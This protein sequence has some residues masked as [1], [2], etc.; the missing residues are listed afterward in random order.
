MFTTREAAEKL[1]VTIRRVNALIAS[2][3]LQAEKF[4]SAWM[5][6]ER[7]VL[8]RL[9]QPVSNGR[10]KMG[11]KNPRTLASY[12]LMNRNHAVLDF[13]YNR[14]TH[15]TADVTPCEDVDWK[16]F[17]TGLIEA[18]PNRYDLATWISSR[19][20]PALRPRLPQ[21][22][23][24]SDVT[25]APDLMLTS[26]G[27]NL[28][29][30]YWFK[31]TDTQADWHE[32]N[33]FENEYEK[34]FGEVLLDGA[35]RKQVGGHTPDT[36]TP[37]MLAKAWMN[38]DGV[39]CLVKG[40][41]GNENRE[42]YNELLAT[43]LLARLLDQNE[44]VAYTLVERHGRTFSA[45]PTMSTAATEFIPAA[46]VLT[47]FGITEGRDV[48]R[49]YLNAGN[50]L[51]IANMSE[52][53]DKMILADHIMANFD[54]HTHNFGLMRNVESREEYRVAP[55]FDNG[56]G[57]YSRASIR[58]LE[59]RSY[60]WEAHPFRLYPSQQLELV[61]NLQW[62]DPECLEGFLDDIATVL[63]QNPSLNDRFIELVQQQTAQRI[64]QV[65]NTATERNALFGGF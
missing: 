5:V 13:T 16:P 52:Q 48:Y 51:G 32:L 54:R 37:G 30:Q 50:A 40:G 33:Y 38:L 49:D 3:D 19:A 14:R 20:I 61:G 8:A 22:L 45:C 17:G 10:P 64:T 4:G 60:V 65:V 29:D 28:S 53:I 46:D 43:K 58:E 47:A 26:W 63:G 9:N 41:F 39:N 7:S 36:A 25:D 35:K 2:G 34:A 59:A 44:F 56:S 1:N 55:L 31:P 15:N 24:N 11:E 12:T 42:P 21:A 57:F 18:A 23:R 62:F 27:L 6:D